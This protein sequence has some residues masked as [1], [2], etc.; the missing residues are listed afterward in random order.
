MSPELHSEP[1]DNHWIDAEIAQDGAENCDDSD[2][3]AGR[4]LNPRCSVQFFDRGFQ[5]K[6]FSA[7]EPEALFTAAR[8]HRL[9]LAAEGVE[10]PDGST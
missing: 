3:T 7:R 5:T 10:Q 1:A 6:R 4:I 8:C 9:K 2:G